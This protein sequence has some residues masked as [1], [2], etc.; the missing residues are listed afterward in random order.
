MVGQPLEAP[1]QEHPMANFCLQ[2]WPLLK[3]SNSLASWLTR[4]GVNRSWF[5]NVVLYVKGGLY[6]RDG[7]AHTVLYHPHP[8][9][10][11]LTLQRRAARV[12]T[13]LRWSIM[14]Q[15]YP[16]P[17]PSSRPVFRTLAQSPL[18]PSP[19][20]WA[21]GV[22][23]C[24]CTTPLNQA[25]GSGRPDH[26]VRPHS[27]SLWLFRD[28]EGEGGIVPTQQIIITQPPLYKNPPNL[29]KPDI[30]TYTQINSCTALLYY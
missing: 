22:E 18:P 15:K 14:R 7:R 3:A 9:P 20:G 17:P 4:S 5:S 6:P 10:L 23:G 1:L 19:G 11:P 26:R 30:H 28:H 16:L 24:C 27:L 13:H 25:Q 12:Q 29:Q 2:C 21:L 8:A